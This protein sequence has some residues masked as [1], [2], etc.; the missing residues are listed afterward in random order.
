MLLMTT[1]MIKSKKLKQ[2]IHNYNTKF[3]FDFTHSSKTIVL[4]T[5]WTIP[6]IPVAIWNS[7][8][9]ITKPAVDFDWKQR[10]ENSNER[11]QTIIIV[12]LYIINE[13]NT[14]GFWSSLREKTIYN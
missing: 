8:V 4:F 7:D 2:K 9:M 1:V 14:V 12:L 5:V 11:I 10:S 6:T 3:C 13:Q